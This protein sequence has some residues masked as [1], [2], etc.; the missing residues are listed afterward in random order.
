MC[1]EPF[2]W[3]KV[4]FKGNQVL[5]WLIQPPFLK[6]VGGSMLNEYLGL[7]KGYL[8]TLTAHEETT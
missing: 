4:G 3:D 1:Y 2:T 6:E 8:H 7:T 5:Q